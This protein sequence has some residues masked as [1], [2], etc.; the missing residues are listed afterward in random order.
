MKNSTRFTSVAIAFCLLVSSTMFAQAPKKPKPEKNKFLEG[1]TFDVQFTEVKEK[2]K[3]AKPIKGEIVI[4]SSKVSSAVLEE[5]IGMLA[6]NYHVTSDT[7][8]KDQEME[9]HQAV[10][11]VSVAEGKTEAKIEAT[12]TN[13]EIT[14]T[15]IELKDGKEKKKYEF[16]GTE[17]EKPG[18]KK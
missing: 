14:G 18:K 10:F 15:A 8:Y 9:M 13:A 1:K 7:T 4:K 6:A 5:K 12:V 3:P 16:T 17:K 2:G 11:E